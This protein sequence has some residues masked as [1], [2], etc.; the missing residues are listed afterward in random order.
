MFCSKELCEFQKVAEQCY[1]DGLLWKEKT[2][3]S[4]EDD[5]KKVYLLCPCGP[6][7]TCLNIGLSFPIIQDRHGWSKVN[8]SVMKRKLLLDDITIRKSHPSNYMGKVVYFQDEACGFFLTNNQNV[9]LR[10]IHTGRTTF[11]SPDVFALFSKNEP[12]CYIYTDVDQ[13]FVEKETGLNA[14]E[15]SDL[16]IVNVIDHDENKK[17]FKLCS[18]QE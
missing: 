15:W 1:T 13:S 10:Y 11:D 4:I 14:T 2:K 3:K 12:E 17:L 8:E 16:S 7:G 6:N 9:I 18:K 5:V